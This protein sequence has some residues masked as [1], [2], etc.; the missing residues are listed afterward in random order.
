VLYVKQNITTLSLGVPEQPQN[1]QKVIKKKRKEKEKKT[2]K[3]K[4]QEMT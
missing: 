2:K 4:S 1:L 3:K